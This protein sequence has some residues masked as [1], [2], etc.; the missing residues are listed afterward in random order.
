MSS[1]FLTKYSIS[2]NF[3]SFQLKAY[4]ILLSMTLIFGNL[5]LAGSALTALRGM[6]EHGPS[7]NIIWFSL[8]MVGLCSIILVL[9]S[10]VILSLYRKGSTEWCPGNVIHFTGIPLESLRSQHRKQLKMHPV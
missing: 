1:T 4:F 8:P 5:T 2:F 3:F 6:F 10:R 7:S 9:T